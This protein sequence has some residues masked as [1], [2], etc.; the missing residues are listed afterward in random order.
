MLPHEDI[1]QTVWQLLE[2]VYLD[3][4]SRPTG[5]IFAG[6][7]DDDKK[8]VLTGFAKEQAIRSQRW[9]LIVQNLLSAEMGGWRYV[10]SGKSSTS[11]QSPV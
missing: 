2:L 6:L 11:R 8:V 7:V 1:A 10:P 4:V 5:L 3:S 9:S